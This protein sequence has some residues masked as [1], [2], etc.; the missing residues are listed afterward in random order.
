MQV[1]GSL[2]AI[3]ANAAT[4]IESPILHPGHVK[5]KK[6]NKREDIEPRFERSSEQ[7]LFMT[8]YGKRATAAPP[9]PFSQTPHRFNMFR[10]TYAPFAA[11]AAELA[12][13]AA[14]KVVTPA[15]KRAREAVVRRVHGT[16]NAADLLFRSALAYTQRLVLA[17]CAPPLTDAASNIDARRSWAEMLATVELLHARVRGGDAACARGGGGAG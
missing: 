12:I 1:G 3:I 10:K 14:P 15:A 5:E 9:T 16:G 6:K 4:K 17:Y 13:S 2:N 8:S 7:Y 11:R